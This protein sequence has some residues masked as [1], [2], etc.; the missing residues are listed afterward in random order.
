[1]VNVPAALPHYPL[2]R[3]QSQPQGMSGCFREEK[4]LFP[5]PRIK[6]IIQPI[7]VTM[8][9][10]LPKR[11]APRYGTKTDSPQSFLV[12]IHNQ[13]NNQVKLNYSS[14]HLVPCDQ[15][16]E[17]AYKQQFT[18]AMKLAVC[19]HF[20]RGAAV[21]SYILRFSSTTPFL[22]C[23]CLSFLVSSPESYNLTHRNAQ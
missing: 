15:L 16:V 20:L 8:L 2:N 12:H 7:A 13:Q 22:T 23:W 4:N 9:T 19:H 14:D 1:V 6:W 21:S 3:R 5:R 17:L 18:V 10:E 11:Y